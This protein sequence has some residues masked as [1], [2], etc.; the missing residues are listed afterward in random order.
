M[1]LEDN[2]QKKISFFFE[3]L[4]KNRDKKLKIN[5]KL[6]VLNKKKVV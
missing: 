5:N 6:K 2:I 4:L 1:E 3:I